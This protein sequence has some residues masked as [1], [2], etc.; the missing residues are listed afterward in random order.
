MR[1]SA[2]EAMFALAQQP[3]QCRYGVGVERKP[4]VGADFQAALP[5]PSRPKGRQQEKAP[6]PNAAKQDPGW[7]EPAKQL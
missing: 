2:P 1:A 4:R 3:C 7:S 6:G 5:E